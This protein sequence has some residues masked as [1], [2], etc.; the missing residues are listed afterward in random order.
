M[1]RT[2]PVKAPAFTAG[3]KRGKIVR[4]SAWALAM[5]AL[6]QDV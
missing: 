1:L 4:F 5:V 2:L 3:G 6:D